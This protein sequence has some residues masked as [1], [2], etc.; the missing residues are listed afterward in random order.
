MAAIRAS[1]GQGGGGLKKVK[2]SDK[3]DRSAAMVP[4]SAAETTAAASSSGGGQQGGLAGALQDALSKRKQRVSGSGKSLVL[5]P[6]V[7]HGNEPA[8]NYS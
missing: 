5:Y 6:I 2:E 8:A 4:G 3:K 7:I 1:G